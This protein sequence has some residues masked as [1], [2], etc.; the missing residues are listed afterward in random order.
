MSNDRFR[1]ESDSIG[2][3]M[4]GVVENPVCSRK[5]LHQL[6]CRVPDMH[7]RFFDGAGN[8][9]LLTT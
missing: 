5:L 7:G 8:S 9:T 2:E 4:R 6:T 3:D 1:D